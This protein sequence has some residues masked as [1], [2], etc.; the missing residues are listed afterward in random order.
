[1][2]LWS[3]IL[4]N[5][6]A[7]PIF[8][9]DT[10]TMLP[11]LSSYTISPRNYDLWSASSDVDTYISSGAVVV[12]TGTRDLVAAL[13][14]A[15]IHDRLAET[16]KFDNTSNGFVST[17]TQSAIEEVRYLAEGR[18]RM[19]LTL[20]ANGIVGAN[21]YITYNELLANKRILFPVR[22]KLLELAWNNSNT[23][24]GAFVFKVFK[25]GTAAGNLIYTYTPTAADRTA[26]YGYEALV[27]PLT[28]V[29]GDYIYIQN[30][31]SSGTSLLDLGLTIWLQSY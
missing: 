20:T 29:A 8:V 7:L 9:L 10:G 13:G 30:V 15:H 26:G 31:R 2:S 27:T 4:K 17:N 1:M 3:K 25:N 22:L 12:S 6:T 16:E 18:P 28:F 21:D 19:G 5:T 14:L 23:S 24:L 11:A